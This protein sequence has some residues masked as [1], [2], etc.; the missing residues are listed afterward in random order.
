MQWWQQLFQWLILKLKRTG[1]WNT[2]ISETGKW[3]A[4]DNLEHMQILKYG[5]ILM[6]GC[7]PFR[8]P[9]KVSSSLQQKFKNSQN[10]LK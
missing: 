2:R 10:A 6:L 9:D 3:E 7:D 8:N 4:L 1:K 5:K